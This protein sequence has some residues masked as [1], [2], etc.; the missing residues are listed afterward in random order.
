LNGIFVLFKDDSWMDIKPEDLES[1]LEA[2]FQS[3]NLNP[4]EI[5][6]KLKQFIEQMSD[7]SGI[8]LSR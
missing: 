7:F 6:L 2:Q 3:I 1:L 5:P 4:Q 8:E